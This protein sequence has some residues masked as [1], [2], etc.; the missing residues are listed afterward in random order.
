[1]FDSKKIDSF[2]EGKSQ[3]SRIDNDNKSEK[4][5]G[6][7]FIKLGFP[8]LAAALLGIMIVAPNI[9]KKIDFS[10]TVTLPKKSEI[11]KLHIEESVITS[12]DKKNRVATV[13]ADSVDEA[14]PGAD[15]LKIIT[16]RAEIPT[17]NGIINITSKDGLF[18]RENNLLQLIN[19]VEA[20]GEKNTVITTEE[21]FY[22]FNDDYGYGVKDIFAVGDWGT[23]QAQGFTFHKDISVLTLKGKNLIKTDKGNLSSTKETKIFQNENKLEAYEN[24]V[25][26]QTNGQTIS[27]DKLIAYF[28]GNGKKEVKSADAFGNVKIVSDRGTATGKQAHYEAAK[29]RIVLQGNTV[30]TSEKGKAYAQKSVYHTLTQNAELFGKVTI[31]TDKGTATGDK[32]FYDAAKQVVDLTGNVTIEQ[33]GNFIKGT[34]AHTDLK[35]SVSTIVADKKE[36]SGNGRIHGTFYNQRKD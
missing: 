29:N 23:M 19:S 25:L 13:W 18:N 28:E 4:S 31:K 8:C 33:N 14:A 26:K 5:F 3:I 21:A 17:D 24:V 6:Y 35:T 7:R 2:F 10:D 27:A 32:G 30:I 9:R 1:M 20:L 36:K 16:P 11:E 34:H 22:N 15:E 12:T